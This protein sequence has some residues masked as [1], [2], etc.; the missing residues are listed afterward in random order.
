MSDPI[1][2][3]L[4]ETLR[5]AAASAPASAELP[6]PSARRLA[7]IRTRRRR[8]AVAVA[9][10][11]AVL[12]A[13][14]ALALRPDR[15]DDVVAVDPS[16]SPS[17]TASVPDV[18]PPTFRDARPRRALSS[19]DSAVACSYTIDGKTWRLLRGVAWDADDLLA[20]RRVLARGQIRGPSTFIACLGP[21]GPDDQ[22]VPTTRGLLVIDPVT[23]DSVADLTDGTCGTAAIYSPR[24]RAAVT[25]VALPPGGV[26]SLLPRED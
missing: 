10:V 1:E 15:G 20:A 26:V 5:S 6:G 17:P 22:N 2:S 11:V 25:V 8:T 4:Q 9:A 19:L 12:G 13:S 3:R 14:T 21:G 7:G 24:F 18:C 16:P 23:G